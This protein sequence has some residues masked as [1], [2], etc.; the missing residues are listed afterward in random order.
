MYSIS[1][2]KCAISLLL[3]FYYEITIII[4]YIIINIDNTP[5]LKKMLKRNKKRENKVRLSDD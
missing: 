4:F 1:F 5:V 3:L 2:F